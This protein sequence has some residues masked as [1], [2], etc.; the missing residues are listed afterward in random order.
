M[1]LPL[2]AEVPRCDEMKHAHDSSH[3]VLRMIIHVQKRY[4]YTDIRAAVGY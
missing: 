4:R 3:H 1:F 2:L